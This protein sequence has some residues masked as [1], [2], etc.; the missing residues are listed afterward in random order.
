MQKDQKN[1]KTGGA[2]CHCLGHFWSLWSLFLPYSFLIKYFQRAAKDSKKCFG[3]LLITFSDFTSF[4]FLFLPYEK[5]KNKN[6][7]S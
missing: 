5:N 1:Q 3:S 7:N 6:K 4:G 2:A